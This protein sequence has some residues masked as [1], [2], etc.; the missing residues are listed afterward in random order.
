L[1]GVTL[2]RTIDRPDT[3]RPGRIIAVV[4]SVKKALVEVRP[5]VIDLLVKV[6]PVICFR[7][8]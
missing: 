8:S 3:I 5:S 7:G 4:F 6:A 1:Q 2:D